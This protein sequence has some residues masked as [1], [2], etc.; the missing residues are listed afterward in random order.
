MKLTVVTPEKTLLNSVSVEELLV[1]G[2]KGEMGIL[3]GHAPL[4]STLGSGILK[5]R[6]C[7][8]KDMEKVAVSWGYCEVQ[9]DKVVVLA[10]S[11]ETKTALDQDKAKKA[12]ETV[13]KKLENLHL[14]PEEIRKL[15]QEEQK[16][17]TFLKLME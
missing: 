4:V 3:P 10:E 13:L 17:R 6:L 2:I 9:P 1:P 14:S 5:Y 15:R 8:K 11:A 12:L 7:E 16:Q